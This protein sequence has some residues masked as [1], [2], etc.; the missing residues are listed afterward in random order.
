VVTKLPAGSRWILRLKG[1]KTYSSSTWFKISWN[2][3][4]GWVDKKRIVFDSHAT[5]IAKNKPS[6][7]LSK[8]RSKDCNA[9]S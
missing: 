3:K 1:T 5:Q 8:T 2:G 4:K 7:L 9:S 6:C